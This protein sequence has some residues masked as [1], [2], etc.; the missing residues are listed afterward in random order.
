[1]TIALLGLKVKVRGQGET[2]KVKVKGRNALD[3][4]LPLRHSTV[5][6]DA[7]GLGS[8][9]DARSVRPRSSIEDSFLVDT[10]VVLLDIYQAKCVCGQ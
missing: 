6:T 3:A 8:Q 10:Q 4:T 9:F 7:L 1:M 5:C 2:S